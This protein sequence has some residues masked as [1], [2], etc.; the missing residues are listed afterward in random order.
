MATRSLATSSVAVA[1]QKPQ[2]LRPSLNDFACFFVDARVL[3][4][5]TAVFRDQVSSRLL[6]GRYLTVNSDLYMSSLGLRAAHACM[7]LLN[8][9]LDSMN[10]TVP[11]SQ[12][13]KRSSRHRLLVV[14]ARMRRPPRH[15]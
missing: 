8:S 12:F 13:V 3:D 6:Y 1:S 2:V 9:I 5:G 11:R 10:S 4:L 7:Q 15:V 14:S